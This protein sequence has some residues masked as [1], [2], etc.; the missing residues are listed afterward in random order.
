MT[1]YIG[2]LVTGAVPEELEEKY[3]PY[4]QMF[5]DLLGTD[6]FKYRIYNVL[7]HQFPKDI[8]ECAGWLVTGSQHGAY[9]KHSWIPP[10][11]N[12]LRHIKQAKKPCIGICFGHQI[13]AQ[14]FGGKVIQNPGGWGVG[15]H[16][17][18]VKEI[19]AGEAGHVS[20]LPN[21]NDTNS[22]TDIALLCVHQDQV[23]E[24]P[25]GSQVILTS[26]FCPVAG[27]FYYPGCVSLQPHPEF[28]PDYLKDILALRGGIKIPAE[29]VEEALQNIEAPLDRGLVKNW[30][31]KHY[32]K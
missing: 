15:R 11:E 2:I 13:M 19:D 32:T 10:L 29:L 3:A 23:V 4:Q 18:H 1:L 22:A 20:L 30:L 6:I 27:L 14:A 26:Q 28:Q 9:E 5:Q 24:V 12:F 7:Q 16:V 8:D 17:Y 31:I 25:S 21:S